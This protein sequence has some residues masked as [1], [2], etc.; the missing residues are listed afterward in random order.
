MQGTTGDRPR[1]TSRPRAK[2]RRVMHDPG[3][4]PRFPLF[5]SWLSG[6]AQKETKTSLLSLSMPECASRVTSSRPCAYFTKP[7]T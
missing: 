6:D 1:G 2:P 3:Y 4:T 7:V 5:W